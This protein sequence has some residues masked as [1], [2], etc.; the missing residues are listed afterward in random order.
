MRLACVIRTSLQ[1]HVHYYSIIV[2]RHFTINLSLIR[3]KDSLGD[4]EPPDIFLL[5]TQA[6]R[7]R[8]LM[9]EMSGVSEYLDPMLLLR[10]RLTLQ[11]SKVDPGLFRGD[12]VHSST[13]QIHPPRTRSIRYW[14]L[15][16]C[17]QTHPSACPA[18]D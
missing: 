13:M 6:P 12:R 1:L 11:Q 16:S 10:C 5:G 2:M 14:L 18:G 17:Y 3:L 8:R 4:S 15:L 9:L 7:D